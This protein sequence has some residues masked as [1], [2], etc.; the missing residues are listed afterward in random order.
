L[1]EQP[2]QPLDEARAAFDPGFRPRQVALRRAV[3]QHE[4]A[5]RIGAVAAMMSSGSTTF[6]FDFDILMTRPI[7]TGWPSAFSVAPSPVRSTSPG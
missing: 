2:P 5:H 6:F 7:S 4:P 3:G 1:A